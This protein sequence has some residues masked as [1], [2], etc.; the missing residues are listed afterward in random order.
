[1]FSIVIPIF[2]K[3]SHLEKAVSSVLS[4]SFN[5]FELILVND[6]STDNS[7]DIVL[8]LQQKYRTIKII[9]QL[10]QG[11]SV[12]RNNGVAVATCSYIAFLDADDWWHP[13]YLHTMKELIEKYPDAGIYGSSYYKVKNQMEMPAKIGVEEDFQ[14]GLINYFQVYSKTLWM[15]LWTGSTIIRKSVFDE[16]NG[17]N[18]N[19]RLGEDFDLW[20]KVA[21]K[22]PVAFCNKALAYYNQDVDD[23]S[24][25]VG[26]FRLYDKEAYFTFNLAYLEEYEKAN[27]QLKFLLDNLRVVSLLRYRLAGKYIEEVNQII[28]GVDFTKLPLFHYLNF[29]LPVSILKWFYSFRVIVSNIKQYL[30]KSKG[31]GLLRKF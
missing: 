14:T 25:G 7:F 26:R 6:G 1:M 5:Q 10:N 15:P 21:L 31:C 20:V 12:A 8:K 18:P 3:N 22:Y 23:A 9:N 27:S 24:R 17:F 13:D 2:N 19:L 30:N 28:Q 16:F 11:V 29:H 4:Q